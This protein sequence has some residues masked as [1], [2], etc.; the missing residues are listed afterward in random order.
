MNHNLCKCIPIPKS[1]YIGNTFSVHCS[2]MC[3]LDDTKKKVVTKPGEFMGFY[4]E[5][6]KKIYLYKKEKNRKKKDKV[7]LLS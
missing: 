3:K 2:T 5:T 6:G 4:K 7:I 1:Q